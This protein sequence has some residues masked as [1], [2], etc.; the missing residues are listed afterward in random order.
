MPDGLHR[1]LLGCGPAAPALVQSV[2]DLTQHL[3]N[4]RGKHL[5]LRLNTERVP[6][7]RI[8]ARVNAEEIKSVVLNLVVNAAHAIGDVV[9]D[10]GVKGR[11]TVRTRQED[12]EAVISIIDTG[13]GIPEAV[14]AR[15]FG[16]FFTTKEVGKGTGQGL[17][18][19]HNVVVNR[20]GGKLSFQTKVGVGTTFHV[21]LPVASCSARDQA[22]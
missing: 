7:G 1:K 17:Y 9:R 18:I 13:G 15:V 3:Q 22:A 20:H 4:S 5:E 12:D 21:R 16:P 10:T 8:L 19:A 14:R 11:I 6:G 2:L